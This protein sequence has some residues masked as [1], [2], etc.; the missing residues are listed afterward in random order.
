MY[1]YVPAQPPILVCKWT[2][3][4]SVHFDQLQISVM[5]SIMK[6]KLQWNRIRA[7]LVCGYKDTYLE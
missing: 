5:V 1:V 6:T 3:S 4:C 2:I 7:M